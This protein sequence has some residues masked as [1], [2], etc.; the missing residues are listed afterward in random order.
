MINQIYNHIK[1]P[2]I[3]IFGDSIKLE[4][5]SEKLKSA[6][7][8]PIFKSGENKH[9]TKY[10][11]ISVLP[12]FS[13]ILEEIMC[14]RIYEYLTKN[15]FLFDKQFGF[16]KGHSTKHALIELLNRIYDSFNENRYSL[17]VLIDL[18]KAFDTVNHNILIKKVKTL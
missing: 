10:R 11:A 7:V 5:F 17:E 16:R 8:T 6:K 9:L 12:C 4:V 13:K 1:K 14:N 18:S 3:R 2:H 15:T